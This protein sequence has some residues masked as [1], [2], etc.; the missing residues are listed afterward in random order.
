M[1]PFDFTAQSAV[2]A[3][4]YRSWLPARLETVYQRDRFTLNLALRTLQGR[5][6]L[7][8]CWHPQAARIHMGSAPPREPDTFAFSQQIQSQ[9]K[10]LALSRI[11]PITPWERALDLEF[12][13]R[14]GE[15][16]LW[17]L[18]VEIMG[19]Y[20]NVLLVNPSGQ[21]VTAANQ[22]NQQQSRVRTIQTGQAYSPPPALQDERPT[23]A[24][25]FERWHERVALVP[26]PIAKN[27]LQVYRGLSSAL[28]RSL[29]LA[30]HLDPQQ[31]S[32]SL[33]EAD[34]KNLFEQWQFWLTC[35]EKEAFT[36]G[37]TETGYTVLGLGM[38]R[39]AASV[40]ELL[41][42]YYGGERDRQR[43]SQV[44]HQIAQKLNGVLKKL[45]H[46]GSGFETR[47]QQS[48]DADRYL[49]QGN[50]L[51]AHLQD[52]RPGLTAMVLTDFDSGEPVKIA[53]NPEKTAVQTAQALYKKHQKL[54]RAR[55]AVEPLL[56]EVNQEI[57]YLEQIESSLADLIEHREPGD[58][59]ALLEIRDELF[60]QGY[61]PDPE[62]RHRRRAEASKTEFHRYESPSGV[63]LL[64][65]RNNRQNDQLTFRQATDYDL[66]LHTQEIPGSHALLR[67][68]PGAAVSEGDLQWAADITAYHSRAR[69]SEQAPVVYTEPKHVYKPKGAQP[70]MVIYKNERVIWGHPQRGKA[71]IAQSYAQS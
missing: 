44:R 64:V 71:A 21:V 17:H 10:G 28:A 41:D 54:K 18:Y 58:L 34:W 31:N 11:Q 15:A 63:P 69:E 13:R 35:L 66:W 29:V 68:E 42:E 59:I 25:P 12:A 32:D 39:T 55:A 45:R 43:F 3:E 50:L 6:W 51:M 7:T 36:P 52:W 16:A 33:R 53:I 37:W 8:L 30:A 5:G 19:K 61:L 46:K 65:G 48:D 20:S 27:M 22:V 14:P 4:L 24:E 70:G 57:R 23:L 62:G 60:Q 26:G 67:L 38:T 47:L 49:A 9:L 40:Q 56:A 2:C 1:Q